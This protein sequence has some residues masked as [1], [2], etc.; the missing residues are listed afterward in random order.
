MPRPHVLL[1]SLSHEALA[2]PIDSPQPSFASA[3]TRG[4]AT[5]LEGQS[6]GLFD[7]FRQA[8][9]LA[10]RVLMCSPLAAARGA[11]EPS[12]F[13]YRLQTAGTEA[14][15]DQWSS[16]DLAFFI[17]ALLDR[18]AL[19]CDAT[20]QPISPLA[21]TGQL[22]DVP[23]AGAVSSDTAP[24][25]V[26]AIGGIEHKLR[27][28]LATPAPID[29]ARIL[30]PKDNLPELSPEHR[31][32]VKRG[33]IVPV[34]QIQDVLD[35]LK[36]LPVLPDAMRDVL[37]DLHAPFEGNPYRG[38]EAFG[39][40]HRG[41]YFGRKPRIDEVLS[42]LPESPDAELPAVL[43]TGFS[44]S[45]KSSL[46]LAGVLGTA[47]YTD[48]RGHRFLPQP[49]GIADAA[50]IAWR[51]PARADLAEPVLCDELQE[52]WQRLLG[53]ALPPAQTL[54]ELGDVLVPLLKPSQDRPGRWVF[55][56]DQLEAMATQA[57]QDDAA[58]QELL[59]R[60][61]HHLQRLIREAGVW[62]LATVRTGYLEALG[63]LWKR[64]FHTPGHVDLNQ[65][66]DSE[67]TALPESERWTRRENERRQFL[68]AII[69]RPAM[70]AG[71]GLEDGLL[72]D[73]I[74][75]AR[76]PQ[77]LPL[78]EF[79]LQ[80]LYEA[81][82]ARRNQDRHASLL[83]RADYDR[84][85]GIRGAINQ[86]ANLLLSQAGEDRDVL[87][88]ALARLA[89]AQAD[90][91]GQREYL[92]T[93]AA[94]SSY[95]A[96]EQSLLLP[97]FS[98]DHRLLT[99]QGDQIEVAHEALLREFTALR[100]WL[101]SH[102]QLLRWRQDHLLPQMRR[103][104]E[105]GCGNTHLILSQDDLDAGEHALHQPQLLAVSET[106]FV[107]ASLAAAKEREEDDRRRSHE[108]ALA[109]DRAAKEQRKALRRTRIG[110][111]MAT[112]LLGAATFLGLETRKAKQQSEAQ[113]IEAA[114]RAAG[115]AG[116]A[117][118][119]GD[120][121]AYN[122]FLSEALNTAE[123]PAA[124]A[125]AAM[126]LQG[127]GLPHPIR[128]PR[129]TLRHGEDLQSARFTLDGRWIMTR[130][131]NGLIRIW[132]AQTGMP[133]GNK[134][135]WKFATSSP[136][137][138]M[139]AT[140]SGNV[141]QLWDTQ[142]GAQLHDDLRHPH[143]VGAIGFS[144]DGRWLASAGHES[145]HLWDT[146]T[147]ESVRSAITH[148]SDVHLVRFSPD[149]QRLAIAG[150]VGLEVWDVQG[151]EAVHVDHLAE[152][153][154]SVQFSPDGE[155]IVSGSSSHKRIRQVATGKAFH[156]S[157]HDDVKQA[158]FSPDGQRV[159][160]IAPD[161]PQWVSQLWIVASG[162]LVGAPI[163]SSSPVH[164]VTF[165]P[166]G[167]FWA[168]TDGGGSRIWEAATGK[169]VADRIHHAEPGGSIEDRVHRAAYMI[170]FQF[171]P[172]GR[173]ILTASEREAQ[174]WEA[175]GGKRIGEP[176]RHE[177]ALVDA[178]FSPDGRSI[179]T[180]DTEGTVRVW[181]SSAAASMGVSLRHRNKV[182]SVDFSPDSRTVLTASN[183][184][185]ARLWDTQTGQQVK[186]L[187]TSDY[188]VNLARFSAEGR[189]IAT[190]DDYSIQRWDAQSGKPVGE[191]MEQDS[192]VQSMQLSPDGRFAM[193]LTEYDMVRIWDVKTGE[194][195]SQTEPHPGR[196]NTAAFSPDSRWI[197]TANSDNTVRLWDVK[198][199]KQIG[200]PLPH[201]EDVHAAVFSPDGRLLATGT[202]DTPFQPGHAYVWD[203]QS[204]Q[205]IGQPIRHEKWVDSVQ[206][207]SDGRWIATACGSKVLRILDVQ[208]GAVSTTRMPDVDAVESARFS[209]DGQWVMAVTDMPDDDAIQ[210]IDARTGIALGTSFRT[211]DEIGA[212]RISPE[213][214]WLAAAG[215]GGTARL[216]PV[217]MQLGVSG[218]RHADA[219]RAL[220]GV[221]VN[222]QGRLVELSPRELAEARDNLRRS[223][224][225]QTPF[226]RVIR[227]HFADPATRT[228]SPFAQQT[229]PQFVEH[230]IDFALHDEVAYDPALAALEQAYEAD[231]GHPL[232]L[233]ALSVV[234]KHPDTVRLWR[235]LTLQR[236]ATDARLAS[237]A[238]DILQHEGDSDNARRAAGI[239]LRLDPAN[240]NARKIIEGTGAMPGR[241][242]P[243]PPADVDALSHPQHR[244]P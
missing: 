81:V 86:R 71:F 214:Q 139:I 146:Q 213:G 175:I 196:I 62:V 65:P 125:A 167:R 226:D 5:R 211:E 17:T 241:T 60:F 2:V 159:A 110:L 183:D 141:V 32:W 184:G 200:E 96:H 209:P 192:R 85:G 122:A 242:A 73:L 41:L 105:H 229:V 59:D 147:G 99:R 145:V 120:L 160:I 133:T 72:D 92:R 25:A 29:Q 16:A 36:T 191:P 174:V 204:R 115:R 77:S 121:K 138:H 179:V 69:E 137:G 188:T 7:S 93:T 114:S 88:G 97:W 230:A 18:L 101:L 172:D 205:L 165:S 117:K 108:L 215:W 78:L 22:F 223:V 42:K 136:D 185:T 129:V 238:A 66:V 40:A 113:L 3:H 13:G 4:L 208:T 219:L 178:A 144:D 234:E 166:D 39:I 67:A 151:T 94:W 197:V 155:W 70:L 217:Q 79:A 156:P 134:E 112:L 228:V 9:D 30:I 203:V 227:W 15:V 46:L 187:L 14:L 162:D 47:L 52:H 82:S 148:S 50:N 61:A 142:T 11:G 34:Q 237:K 143:A 56:L 8:G 198:S 235:E 225:G 206:F 220:S 100:D 107:H 26:R 103:W 37:R 193:T 124:L 119:R 95:S 207:S 157:F 51:V 90:A 130:D 68:H 150:F 181:S 177:H 128:M 35:A 102:A 43:I 161:G 233:L 58:R 106:E 54:A 19:A 135:G 240:V 210:I 27:A 44:G 64:V 24:H 10:W 131:S 199:G 109:N 1:A 153:V 140:V 236:I 152:H 194:L 98:A 218:K 55:A 176:M 244:Q 57:A 221:E 87:L 170:A 116:D 202:G 126:V 74:R 158:A 212:A 127:Q 45:G 190:T 89:R 31:I 195:A 12:R 171:S 75:D 123:N 149:G 216:W 83:T 80:G 84:I 189:W 21:A 49:G 76:D 182:N 224:T 28:A 53:V 164:F 118:Q 111:A 186:E 231:P 38:I 239:A 173:W 180:A 20:G 63:P 232:I 132:D 154:D 169:L 104:M 168:M 48:V 91:N 163:R 23:Q 222:A 33:V 243:A 6:D 201:D